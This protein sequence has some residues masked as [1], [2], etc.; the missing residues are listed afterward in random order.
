VAVVPVWLF[1]TLTTYSVLHNASRLIVRNSDEALELQSSGV[2]GYGLVYSVFVAVPVIC[3]L[4]KARVGLTRIQK[5]LL[6]LTLVLAVV[7]VF[8]A[9]YAIAVILMT[10]G[11]ATALLVDRFESKSVTRLAAL[12]LVFVPLAILFLPPMVSWITD[13]SKGTMYE[14]KVEDV[15]ASLS[16]EQDVGTVAGRTDRYNRSIDLFVENPVQGV[17]SFRDIGKHSAILDRLARFGVFFGFMFLYCAT[18]LP[19]RYMRRPKSLG[20]GMALSV[21][22]VAIPFCF[23]NNVFPGFGYM[24]FLFFPIAMSYIEEKE[25]GRVEA[26]LPGGA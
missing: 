24:L 22:I 23:L 2:G 18:F 3:Y 13:A 12:V 19:L 5:I 8:M 15:M 25:R 20:F 10:L 4:L 16:T 6:V 14:R 11:L 9:G 17:L 7:V 1:I 26:A 21:A